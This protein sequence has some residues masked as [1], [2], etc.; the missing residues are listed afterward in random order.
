M[1]NIYIITGGT[2]AHVAPHFSICAPAYGK[3]GR[4]ILELLRSEEIGDLSAYLINTSMAGENCANTE[5]HLGSLGFGG[6][7]ETNE[8]LSELVDVL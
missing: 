8:D 5:E 3:V 7:L 4:Q 6:R 2:M 1:R